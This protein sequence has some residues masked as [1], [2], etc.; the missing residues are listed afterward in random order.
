VDGEGR[1]SGEG[2]YVSYEMLLRRLETR[3]NSVVG[4]S[5]SFFAA[6]R[7]VCRE[8]STDVPSDFRILFDAVR[9][10]TEVYPTRIGSYRAI[11][12]ESQEFEWKIEPCSGVS[13]R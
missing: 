12:D 8:W 3:A 5:G 4:L 10:S 11:V 1:V 6:R 7:Q 13:P 2:T 9:W